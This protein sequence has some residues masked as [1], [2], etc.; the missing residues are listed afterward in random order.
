M[1]KVPTRLM[2]TTRAKVARSCGPS[3]PSTFLGG[4]TPAQLTSPCSAPN[5]FTAISMAARALA[6]SVTS[7]FAKR[8]LGPSCAACAS[9]APASTSTMTTFAPALTRLLAVSAPSPDPAPVTTNT[10]PLICIFTPKKI[11]RHHTMP[12][13]WPVPTALLENAGRHRKTR[14]SWRYETP[15]DRACR[16][17]G[18]PPR[19]RPHRVTS[20]RQAPSRFALV[21]LP[22]TGGEQSRHC[23]AQT[24]TESST[25]RRH[26]TCSNAGTM[27]G[28]VTGA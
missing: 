9:P 15:W 18:M 20:A 5:S 12:R 1:L 7:V 28:V 23:R 27:P 11:S 4:A 2:L 16:R 14:L 26:A 24:T 21:D 8:A 25:E 13:Y 3:R 17:Q 10:L 22:G 6:S 19:N